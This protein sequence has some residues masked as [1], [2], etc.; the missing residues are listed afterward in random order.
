MKLHNRNI[1]FLDIN[2]IL[3]DVD[4]KNIHSRTLVL[5][6]DNKIGKLPLIENMI[7][8]IKKYTNNGVIIDSHNKT[9]YYN[10]SE[11]V[12]NLLSTKMKKQI[13]KDSDKFLIVD[14]DN[15]VFNSEYL[16]ILC[17]V[18]KLKINTTVFISDSI[19]NE[20]N[21]TN[22]NNLIIHCSYKNVYVFNEFVSKI[23]QLTTNE[24][25]DLLTEYENEDKYLVI[26]NRN[27]KLYY[28]KGF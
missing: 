25:N 10:F 18:N 9:F 4:G 20:I 7:N 6:S 14:D 28:Y 13:E 27:R 21:D 3:F 16:D 5:C 24:Y 8:K 23:T 11:N 15:S 17:N 1:T 22:I 19:G 26:D 12:D 2:D